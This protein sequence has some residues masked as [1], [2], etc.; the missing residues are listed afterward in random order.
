MSKRVHVTRQRSCS[1][2][3]M[4]YAAWG[5]ASVATT[6]SSTHWTRWSRAWQAS[7]T[8]FTPWRRTADRNARYIMWNRYILV[9]KDVL[10][11]WYQSVL[12]MWIIV[13]QYRKYPSITVCNRDLITLITWRHHVYKKS[14][15]SVFF[16]HRS[17]VNHQDAKL[18]PQTLSPGHLA[19]VRTPWPLGSIIQTQAD[20][21][22]QDTWR[23]SRFRG[24]S[25]EQAASDKPVKKK[26]VWESRISFF[27]A[28]AGQW[29]ISVCNLDMEE[30]VT[31]KKSKLWHNLLVSMP[32]TFSWLTHFRL[33]W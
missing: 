30:E 18:P 24:L 33:H 7:R 9:Y 15:S 27:L 14:Q 20:R 31:S 21:E 17:G 8:A 28:P 10:K 11:S 23:W 13:C 26:F 25:A 29:C 2:Y 6:P 22:Q 32:T 1:W 19:L 16:C 5:T 3:M 12:I 4:R